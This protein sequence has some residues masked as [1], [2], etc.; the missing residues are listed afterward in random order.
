MIWINTV[1]SGWVEKYCAN[2]QPIQINEWFE[3]HRE[4]ELGDRAHDK[5]TQGK[6]L[7]VKPRP[8]QDIVQDLRSAYAGLFHQQQGE[9]TTMT[10]QVMTIPASKFA[11]NSPYSFILRENPVK[12]GVEVHFPPNIAPGNKLQAK[13]DEFN[14][15]QSHKNP[16]LYYVKQS[17]SP[18]ALEYWRKLVKTCSSHGAYEISGDVSVDDLPDKARSR[19][20]TVS[21]V[22]QQVIDALTERLDKLEAL[23]S[24]PQVDA[25]KIETLEWKLNESWIENDKLKEETERLEKV[26]KELRD[27]KDALAQE[28]DNLTL[29]KDAIAAER[30]ELAEQVADLLGTSE[31]PEPDLDFD[32][33]NLDEDEDEDWEIPEGL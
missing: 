13:L 20:A 28:L 26:Y 10:T 23:V 3:N 31:P 16:S 15:A 12:I 19:T 8:N 1:P 9:K 21:P 27:E 24:T 29:E 7:G 30:D 22:A 4:C 32:E 25:T 2:P 14:F 18:K 5:L 17:D 11:K 6:R 33:P